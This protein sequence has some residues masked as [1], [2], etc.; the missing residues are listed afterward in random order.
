MESIQYSYLSVIL[1][2][3]LIWGNS[4]KIVLVN[5]FHYLKGG[6]ETY[7]FALGEML[8]DIGHD[9]IYFSMFDERNLPCKQEKY[10]VGNI[11]YN[12][13]MNLIQIIKASAKLLYSFEAKSKFN[14]LIEDERPDIIHLNIFQR[15]LTSSIIDVAVKHNIPLV[16]TAHDLKAVCPTYLMMNHGAICDAC[17]NGNY[18]NCIKTSCMKDSKAKSVLA[19][20]ESEIYRINKVYNKID[21]IICPSRHHQIKLRQ[22]NI[23]SSPIVY[24]PNF[25]PCGTEFSKG[26]DKGNYFL[27][28]GRLSIEKG[29]MTLVKA[30]EISDVYMSLYIVG[31]GP[32]E[33]EIKEYIHQ[34]KLENKIFLKGFKSGDELQE[35]IKNSHCVCLPSECC[36]NAPYS[37]MEAQACGRP[38]IVS[39]NGGL[40]E[41]IEDEV[42]GFIF[43]AGDIKSL[44]EKIKQAETTVFNSEHIVEQAREYYSSNNYLKRL[45]RLYYKVIRKKRN[46]IVT[47]KRSL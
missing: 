44:S 8:N 4:L 12:S 1:K 43:K 27:F 13:K 29:I 16:Y 39:D 30:F 47:A 40:P 41:L 10:F 18:W 2:Y 32:Q 28:F 17:I 42:N 7:Y 35:I 36:E 46:Y 15:Q 23:T 9:V 24:L 25:L 37:I 33:E 31:T 26:V 5:K 34:H 6:S 14:R 19:A 20:I 21:L 45:L 38:A 3:Y 11:D 22:G